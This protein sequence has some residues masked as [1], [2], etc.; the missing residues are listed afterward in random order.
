V[1]FRLDDGLL[2]EQRAP[3]SPRPEVTPR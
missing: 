2:S 3:A 1:V